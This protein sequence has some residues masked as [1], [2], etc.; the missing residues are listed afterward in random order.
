MS[1]NLSHADD[2]VAPA[3]SS[4]CAQGTAAYLLRKDDFAGFDAL[5]SGEVLTLDRA[6]PKALAGL[7]AGQSRFLNPF[8]T[9]RFI[10]HVASPYTPIP[11]PGEQSG[12]HT[13]PGGTL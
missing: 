5:V 4:P 1:S 2:P 3:A 6:D 13:P 12:T 11:S 10:D 7:T 8:H 9:A